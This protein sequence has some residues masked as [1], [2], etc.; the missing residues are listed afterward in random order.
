MELRISLSPAQEKL[1]GEVL[2]AIRVFPLVVLRCNAGMGRSSIL[3]SLRDRIGG[4][5]VEVCEFMTLLKDREPSA[6]EETFA[7]LIEASIQKEGILIIDDLHLIHRVADSYAYTRQQL[8]ELVLTG[9][10]DVA[11][12]QNKT[13]IYGVDEGLIPPPLER[14]GIVLALDKFSAEDYT[15]VCEAYLTSER[16]KCIDYTR[17]HR[18][19]PLLN[20]WQLRKACA[21]LSADASLDTDAFVAYLSE[22]HLTSNVET[23]EV[24]KVDWKDLKGLDDIIVALE[25]KVALP[26]ENHVLADELNLKARRGVLLAGPP[27]TGKTTI[28]RALA[29]RLK[30]KFF[31]ID[32]T[33]IAEGKDFYETVNDIFEAAVRNSPSVVFIDDTDVIF[34]NGRETGLYRYLLTKL[35]GLESASA[36]RVCVMM[37]AMDAGS[38]PHALLRSGRIELWL[39]TRLPDALARQ[40][41]IADCLSTLP[42]PLSGIDVSLIAEAS[43]GLSGADLKSVIEDGKLLLAHDRSVGKSIRPLEEYLLQAIDT[44]RSNRRNYG[45]RKPRPFG[46][47]ARIGFEQ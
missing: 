7:D 31:L 3:R 4:T 14:R 6:F 37:T 41:I 22:H 20:A 9:L 35:D 47:E 36:D 38:L 40:T 42:Q 23:D 16:N 34:E 18:F 8:L 39:E 13:M 1:A 21:S 33:V 25:A 24:R 12:S 11:V 32:G 26:F 5:M 27:G 43:Q 10:L 17:V 30:G 15:A 19:A 2:A 46:Q 44:I 28:G 29:H 45:K